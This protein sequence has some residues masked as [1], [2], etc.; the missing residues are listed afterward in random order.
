M[1]R[2]SLRACGIDFEGTIESAIAL[3]PW[4]IPELRPH[5]EK[6]RGDTFWTSDGRRFLTW[7]G[8]FEE[9]GNGNVGEWASYERSGRG[10]LRFVEYVY[11]KRSKKGQNLLTEACLQILAYNTLVD[12]GFG[13]VIARTIQIYRRISD[14]DIA[15]TMEP[16]Y[17]VVNLHAALLELCPRLSGVAFD[18]WFIPILVQII[19]LIGLLEERVGINHR[20]L[21]G[22]N[23]L[24]SKDAE[25]K[26]KEV[27]LAGYTWNFTYKRSVHVVDFGFSCRGAQSG[28]AATVSAGDFFTLTDVCPK[29]GRDVYVLLCY[30][31]AQPHWRASAS[32][33]LLDFVRGL[34]RSRRMLDHLTTHGLSRTKY[35]Y[36]LLSE[37]D[38]PSNSCTPAAVLSAIS[39]RWPALLERRREIL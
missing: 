22:D 2:I 37:P 19:M 32:S 12:A 35:I 24:I 8:P 28:S 36:F 30:F 34:L 27:V 11:E 3:N 33:Q 20:D 39:E 23:I 1:T 29:D 26:S 5:F 17:R 4:S 13:H 16:F 14:N 18:V 9:G 25:Q 31:Y 6:E 15:F 7:I 21:K 38:F 10:S